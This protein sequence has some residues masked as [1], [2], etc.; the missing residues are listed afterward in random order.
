[1]AKRRGPRRSPR[2]CNTAPID[3]RAA[4][5]GRFVSERSIGFGDQPVESF[6]SGFFAAALALTLLGLAAES[7]AVATGAPLDVAILAAMGGGAVSAA[8]GLYGI[9]GDE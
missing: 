4:G 7:V 5:V 6:L 2:D 9:L 1:M 3:R 8:W